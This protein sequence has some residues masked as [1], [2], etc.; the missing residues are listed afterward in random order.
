[1]TVI[2][3]KSISGITSITAPAGS[4]DLLT[5]HTND[6]TERFRVVD[7]GAIVTGVTTA[8]N[9]KTG[10]TNVH[11]VGVELA[12][13]NVLGA[14]TPIGT[15]ATIYNSGAAVF[16]GIV[17]ATNLNVES[18]VGIGSVIPS[19]TLDVVGGFQGL[20]IY[21][22]DYTGSGGAG[23]NL[24]FGG[25][26]ADGTIFN[27]ALISGIR[28]DNT[29][30]AGELRFSVLTGGTMSEKVRITS[31]GLVG[32]TTDA[33]YSVL[34]AYGENK[35]DSGSATGQITAKDNAAWNASPTGGIIFQGH[36]HSN[37]ANAVFGGIT[38]FKE[39][40][41][42]GNYAAALAFHVRKDGE[43]A[44]ERVRITSAGK[45]GIGTNNP[46]QILHLYEAAT[47]SQCYL[48][49]QN[50][51]SRNAAVQFTTTSGSWYVGQGI[52]AD[53][54]R[55]MVYD[56][57]ERFSVDANGHT[58]IH[59]GNLEF[60]NGNGIDFS[61]VPDG[62]RSI[63]TDG[64][65]FDDYEE[66]TWTPYLGTNAQLQLSASYTTQSGSYTKLGNLVFVM[67]DLV[68]SNTPSGSAG[69]PLISG[70]PFAPLTGQSTQG[71][72][73]VPSFRSMSAAPADM[74]AYGTDSYGHSSHSSIWI[75]YYNSSGVS[76]Q[77]AG[78]TF[79]S[80]GR[81]TGNLTYRTTT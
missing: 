78:G 9:F 76:Q 50:N 15:G 34:T 75:A 42:E 27:A 1:M 30:Q 17:T 14:D 7:S 71:G 5:V 52:G 60:A 2:N 73:P 69:Y 61:A 25:K 38:G 28:G 53:V 24:N 16:T 47:S 66:G 13:I 48:K 37:N 70:L 74:R 56:S 10:T 43:V 19:N 22:G 8:S 67:F 36:Y 11:N 18:K 31:T 40:G 55:F 41:T 44:K 32:I 57:Q 33:P 62:S 21:R 64:N 26:K 45:V 12:G 35:S 68:V 58:K 51:R 49:I 20:G 81:I 77:P 46:D 23:I 29:A 54:D 79:W 6:T 4:D 59:T 3:H 80:S 72:F 65:K 63:S 39:N